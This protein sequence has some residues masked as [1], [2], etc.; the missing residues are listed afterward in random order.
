MSLYVYRFPSHSHAFMKASLPQNAT[1]S[2]SRIQFHVHSQ[3]HIIIHQPDFLARLKRWQTNVRTPIASERIS[4]RAIATRAH[5]ALHR[6]IHFCQIFG[7]QFGQVGI[8]VGPLRCIFGVQPLRET[9]AAI[10][11]RAAALGV[12]FAGFGYEK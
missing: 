8:C 10:F 3:L 4:Q 2:Q 6:E 1:S 12:G 9:A 7:L 11:A 5:F